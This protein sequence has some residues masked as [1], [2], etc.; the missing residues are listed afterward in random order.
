MLAIFLHGKGVY[1]VAG[2][3]VG[4]LSKFL[5]ERGITPIRVPGPT[6]GLVN[7]VQRMLGMT[8]YHS[9]FHPKRLYY[10]L[11]LDDTRFAKIFRKNAD[12]VPALARTPDIE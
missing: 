10:S 6:L 9:G 1:N 4:P 11:V 8:R 5:E 7:R 2:L 3:T 12:N